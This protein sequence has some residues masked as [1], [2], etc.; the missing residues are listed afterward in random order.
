MN[1]LEYII[2]VFLKGIV[3]TLFIGVLGKLGFVGMENMSYLGFVFLTYILISIVS[4]IISKLFLFRDIDGGLTTLI[5]AIFMLIVLI[6]VSPPS[7][8]IPSIFVD[9][10]YNIQWYAY[11]LIFVFDYVVSLTSMLVVGAE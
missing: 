1:N 9:E 6:I 7:L 3:L 10:I 4:N 2:Q 5:V 11:A 8:L